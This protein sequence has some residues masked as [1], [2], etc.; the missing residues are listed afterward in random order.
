MKAKVRLTC[1]V[2]RSWL[3]DGHSLCRKDR[4]VGPPKATTT[5]VCPYHLEVP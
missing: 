3:R 2:N 4:L 1:I 5:L